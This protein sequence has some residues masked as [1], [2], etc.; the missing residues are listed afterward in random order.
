[1]GSQAQNLERQLTDM[2]SQRGPNQLPFPED[3]KWV[4]RQQLVDLAQEVPSLSLTQE[5]FTYDNGRS[6]NALKEQGTIPMY[7]QGSK[8]N[9]PVAIWLC[10]DYP[11]QPPVVF[12][13]PTPDMIIK[14]NHSF[15]NPSGR[16]DVL[17]LRE[18]VFQRSNLVDLCWSL[19]ISFGEDPPLFS[20]PP[21]WQPP[22]PQQ[23]QPRPPPPNN[24]AFNN[25]IVRPSSVGPGA[26]NPYANPYASQPPPRPAPSARPPPPPA[27]AAESSYANPIAFHNPYTQQQQQ[28]PP[29]PPPPSHAVP[30][31]Y[32]SG[33]PPASHPPPPSVSQSMTVNP[34]ELAFRREA[35]AKLTERLQASIKG[36]NDSVQ[37]RLGNMSEI[38]KELDTRHAMLCSGLKA[39]E[40][41]REALE[42]NVAAM[43]SKT[44]ELDGW[45]AKHE[46][47]AKEAGDSAFSTEDLEA[48]IVPADNLSKHALKAAAEDTA[49]EDTLY[50]L[51]RGLQAGIVD[52]EAY[53]KQ[54][55]KLCR[56]QF[57]P[58]ALGHKVAGLQMAQRQ[59]GTSASARGYQG[60]GELSLPQ[61]DSWVGHQSGHFQRVG[62]GSTPNGV[63]PPTA[64]WVNPLSAAA[65]GLQWEAGIVE[66][67]TGKGEDGGSEW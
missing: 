23:P 17:Y 67:L 1:M 27:A 12:V 20:K 63:Q 24:Q 48:A 49:I 43:S 8:Y 54:V 28:R 37:V 51:E 6:T 35:T 44:A 46:G 2:L 26:N 45:L 66:G 34:A 56:K 53:L 39:M 4:V 18:W 13:E 3:A 62:S 58:R 10:E 9:I 22:P 16:V 60:N 33:Q 64:G 52:A 31:P 21:G 41:E 50:S 65:E 7:Y 47:K 32:G 5:I 59:Q 14:P 11:R 38:E 25:P 40:A 36:H 29:P 30:N 19:G 61:G 15:V 57:F 55:R 42:R